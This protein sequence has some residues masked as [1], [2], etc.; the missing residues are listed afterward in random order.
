MLADLGG[1]PYA[2]TED[3]D[4][5]IIVVTGSKLVRVAT[6]GKVTTIFETNYLLLGPN[7]LAVTPSGV[8]Y[9]GMR[10]FVTR[11]TPA[12]GQYQED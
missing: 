5:S 8:I 3:R 11:L 10:H 4:G 6:A 7:S 9:V 12:G 2:Y 1:A